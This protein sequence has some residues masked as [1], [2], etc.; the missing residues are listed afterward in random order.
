MAVAGSAMRWGEAFIAKRTTLR[1]FKG[2]KLHAVRDKSGKFRDIQTYKRAHTADIRRKSKAET[3]AAAKKKAS[4]R[5]K[6]T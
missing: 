6:R 1:S 5:S 3:A 2:I 4:S